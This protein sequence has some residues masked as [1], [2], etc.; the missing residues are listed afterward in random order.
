MKKA[1]NIFTHT[2]CLSQE[3]LTKYASDKLSPAEKHEVEKHLLDCEMCSDAVE[4]LKMIGDNNK[5]SKIISELDRKI[6][7]RVGSHQKEVKVIFLQQYRSQ[8]AIAASV[9][10]LLVLV[11][12]FRDNMSMKELDPAASEKIFADKF[13]PY[14]AEEDEKSSIEA[15]EASP[16]PESEI[17]DEEDAR[18]GR[19]DKDPVEAKKSSGKEVVSRQLSKEASKTEDGYSST[20]AEETKAV[21]P[22]AYPPPPVEERER[23]EEAPAR[24]PEAP[25]QQ[26]PAMESFGSAAPSSSS[27]GAKSASKKDNESGYENDETESM[28]LSTKSSRSKSKKSAE[29]QASQTQES[30]ADENK[31]IESANMLRLDTTS[32]GGSTVGRQSAD[33]AMQKYEQKN[34]AGA[35]EDFEKTLAKEPNNY[36]ALFYSAVSYLST[37]QTD[38]AITNLNKVL[39]KKNGELY[40]AAQWYL[41]LAYIKKNDTQNARKN[42]IELQNNSNSKYQ[43]QADET[44]REMKK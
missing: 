37:D 34:Y 11:F 18:K 28:T 35:A 1:N 41:S 20:S 44:L 36:N 4:G 25:K 30:L 38:K 31:M 12:F 7:D 24:K 19:D 26:S 3:M 42:L 43:K 21:Q 40:D 29:P 27:T 9:I 2:D 33:I 14:P 8:L 39:E 13:E 22:L 6:L 5:I 15:T 23:N 10:V 17:A 16:V 32:A